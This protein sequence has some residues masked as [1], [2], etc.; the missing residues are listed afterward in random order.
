M[1]GGIYRETWGLSS[2]SCMLYNSLVSGDIPY[3]ELDL[4]GTVSVGGRDCQYGRQ[5]LSVWEFLS[6][7]CEIMLY[8]SLVS[9]NIPYVEP[10]L[11]GAVSMGGRDCQHVRQGLSVWEAGTVSVG[12]L[13]QL[14]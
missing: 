5:E 10:D 1:T 9:G 6:S 13:I 3:M 8:N 7:L 4:A 2:D 12:V 14:V 11:A